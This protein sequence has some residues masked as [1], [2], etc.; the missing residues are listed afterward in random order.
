MKVPKN[1][2][3]KPPTA[4]A[5]ALRP[6]GKRKKKVTIMC[7]VLSMFNLAL[8]QRFLLIG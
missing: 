7:I 1:C 3:I 4:E 5:M 8:K 2:L 6:Q